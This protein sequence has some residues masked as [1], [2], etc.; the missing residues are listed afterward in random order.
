MIVTLLSLLI[1]FATASSISVVNPLEDQLPLI[2]RIDVPYRWS[3][4]DSTFESSQNSSLTYSAASLPK[5]LTLDSLSR[6]FQGTPSAQDEGSPEVTVTA[7]D[8]VSGDSASSDVTLCVTSF[9]A[10]TLNLPIQSQFQNANPSLSSVF[11]VSPS[12]A[13]GPGTPTLRI[14]HAW[15]FSIGLQYDTFSSDHSLYYDALQMDG[16]PLPPWL[17]F[18]SHTVTFNG[19]TPSS[20]VNTTQRFSIALHASDQAGYSAASLPFDIVVAS[21]EL[22]AST[23]SLPTI[24]ITASTPFMVSLA[25]PADFSGILVDGNPIQPNEITNLVIDPSQSKWLAYDATNRALS[26]QPL[27][28]SSQ[29]PVLPVTLTT[30]FNQTIHT[31]LSLAIVPSYFSSSTLNPVLLQPGG[32]LDFNLVQYFSNASLSGQ[33]DDVNLTASFSP[34]EA[35]HYLTFDP[36][37]AHLKGS[38]PAND[39]DDNLIFNYDHITT[40]FTAYSHVTHSTSH[41]TLSISLSTESYKHDHDAHTPG[42][43][44]AAHRK[45]MIALVIVFAVLGGIVLLGVILAGFRKWA[46]VD[47]GVV[48]GGESMRGFNEVD[49]KWYRGEGHA[50]QK[51]GDEQQE[52]DMEMGYGAQ[53]FPKDVSLNRE[54]TIDP[55]SFTPLRDR[56]AD[57]A[58]STPR[59]PAIPREPSLPFSHR[60]SVPSSNLVTKGQFFGKLKETARNV[61]DR[62]KRVR[63]SVRRKPLVISKPSLIGSPRNSMVPADRSLHPLNDVQSRGYDPDDV[64]PLHT[65]PSSSTRETGTTGTRSIPHRRA[66]FTPVTKPAHTYRP[67]FD[68]RRSEVHGDRPGSTDSIATYASHEAQAVV[69]TA[70]RARSVKSVSGVSANGHPGGL[71]QSPAMSISMALSAT[72]SAKLV[73]FTKAKVP[74]PSPGASKNH[75]PKRIASQ[76]V[77]VVEDDGGEDEDDLS[78]GARYVEALGEETPRLPFPRGGGGDDSR[79]ANRTHP[80]SDVSFSLSR[81]SSASQPGR[82]DSSAEMMFLPGKQLRFKV[83]ISLSNTIR[84]LEPRMLTSEGDWVAVPSFL[85]MDTKGNGDETVGFRGYFGE[86]DLGHYVIGVFAF[87]ENQCVG[88]IGFRVQHK[89]LERERL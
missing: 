69:E 83:K 14:P 31:N 52:Q 82:N 55:V 49:R 54:P 46:R 19:Y 72:D 39:S 34:D 3:F 15:S 5:W 51:V 74:Q 58:H 17:D 67:G 89:R 88:R 25:S 13:L 1:G 66:D 85:N 57:V 44:D 87:P 24:N 41:T 70:S 61:S 76:K 32:N 6:T 10:P 48:D 12:S 45:L 68:R 63:A 8:L 28:G 81:D 23:S 18:D 79:S 4:A 84:R 40:T 30:Y 7:H 22:S 75:G 42:L 56:Y 59:R 80:R 16:S 26:G 38:L 78:M 11:L 71:G 36:Q 73:E 86:G 60:S 47:D 33:T 20:S 53:G 29:G 37:S 64:M 65:S 77:K 43:S 35:S 62:Y 9:P 27:D 2:A 21:H 50:E